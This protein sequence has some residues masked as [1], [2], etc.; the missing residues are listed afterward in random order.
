MHQN[1]QHKTQEEKI[2]NNHIKCHR[3]TY[4]LQWEINKTGMS[5]HI[6]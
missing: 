3:Q 2:I 4:I 6:L 1:I 5:F